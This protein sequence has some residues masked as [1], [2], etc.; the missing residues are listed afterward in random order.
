MCIRDRYLDNAGGRNHSVGKKDANAFGLYDV[1]GNVWEWTADARS[2]YQTM[3]PRPG[4]GLRREPEEGVYLIIRGGSRG[5]NADISRSGSRYR[6]HPLGRVDVIGFRP[7]LRA[8]AVP[9][10][11]AVPQ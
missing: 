1:A 4:D 5:S 11:G 9:Q 6:N 2:E 7:V 10:S 3:S 8:D